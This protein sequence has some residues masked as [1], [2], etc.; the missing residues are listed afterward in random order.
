VARAREV[1]IRRLVDEVQWACNAS[2]TS[3][4]PIASVAPPERG[5]SLSARERQMRARSGNEPIDGYITFYGPA[6]VVATLHNA[7]AALTPP[8]QPRWRGLEALLDHAIAEWEAQPRHRDPIFERDGWRCTVPACSSRR[9]L[10]DHHIVFRSRGGSNAFY[11]R[12]SLCAWHHLRG[13]HAGV[14]RASGRAPKAIRWELGRR[15]DGEPL[16]TLVGDYYVTAM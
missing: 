16:L 11:N 12:V 6:A 8:D 13:I 14:V 2:D 9:N 4:L 3:E 10:Q 15:H 5:A 7:V 1:T